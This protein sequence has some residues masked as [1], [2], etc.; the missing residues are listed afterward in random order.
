MQARSVGFPGDKRQDMASL[1]GPDR[2]SSVV[3]IVLVPILL[4]YM[5]GSLRAQQVSPKDYADCQ[6]ADDV[7]RS[8]AA[9]GRIT[10]DSTQ[11][12]EDRITA[13]SW[14]GVNHGAA[15]A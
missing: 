12:D 13:Y 4:M 14:L 2:R 7:S 3:L 1:A 8:I 6:K 10:K 5:Q 15:G 11:S 9:C